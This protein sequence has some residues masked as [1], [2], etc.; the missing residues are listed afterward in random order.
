MSDESN[1]SIWFGIKTE[2]VDF[3]ISVHL[4]PEVY[5]RI[6]QAMELE[7]SDIEYTFIYY[8]DTPI[9]FG[10]EL[11]EQSAINGAAELHLDAISAELAAIRDRVITQFHEWGIPEEPRLY[12]IVSPS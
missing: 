7:E 8:G 4:F 10:V 9:G 3:P 1:V 6:T 11:H 12:C 2:N 5:R